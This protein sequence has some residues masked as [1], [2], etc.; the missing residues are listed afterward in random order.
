MRRIDIGFILKLFFLI[1]IIWLL[2]YIGKDKNVYYK[3][4]G[5]YETR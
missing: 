2:F 5:Y 4:K 1:A 3:S